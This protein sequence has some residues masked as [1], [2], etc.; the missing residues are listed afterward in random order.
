M[1]RK[2]LFIAIPL[3]VLLIVGLFV[4]SRHTL[5]SSEVSSILHDSAGTPPESNGVW[6][7]P[8]GLRTHLHPLASESKLAEAKQQPV[9]TWDEWL[10]AT[11]EVLLAEAILYGK[12]KTP[13]FTMYWRKDTQEEVA[14]RRQRL[15]ESLA[16]YIKRLQWWLK[17]PP[18]Y[19]G[20]LQSISE[21]GDY[22]G[23]HPQTAASLLDNFDAVFRD[24]HPKAAYLDEHYLTEV[25]LKTLLEKG[26]HFN[27]YNDYRFYLGVRKSLL[28]QKEKPE[29]W[30]SG[31]HDLP[32]TT[33][34]EEYS[35]GFIDRKVWEYN[36]VQKVRAENPGTSPTVYFDPH[37]PDKYFPIV[38]SMTYVNL[39]EDRGRMST[40]GTMLTEEQRENL[41]NK[42]IKPKGIE[43]IYLDDD[44]NVLS[45][46]PPLVDE[47]QRDLENMV[48]FDGIKV[49]PENYERLL[50]Q[51]APDK[52][53]ESYER[54]QVRETQDTELFSDTDAIRTAAREAASAA[55]ETAKSEFE[56]FQQGMRQLEEFAS[57]SDAEIEKTLEKQFRQK[58]L[59]QLPTEALEQLTPERLEN[60]LGTLF[61]HGFDEGFRRISRDSPALAEQLKQYF[62]QGQK[63]PAGKLPKG[64]VPPAPP[65]PPEAAP[66]GTDTD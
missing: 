14:L 23:S 46:P 18:E 26:A 40:F 45:E 52:W 25:W 43:I 44:N 28:R 33:N 48:S 51:P 39:G 34:F 20:S 19:P 65:A 22:Q 57:M 4:F 21:L 24:K 17:P 54:E 49:T 60:A 35:D 15:Q 66:P 42:G 5:F 9:G 29:E 62:G 1:R 64:P 10:D 12:I 32:I 61:Q 56:K 3:L 30:I 36:I 13:Y 38:G 37:D 58:F 47:R 11:V 41:L 2:T 16:R 8:R 53:L 50:G 55:Q 6:S 7:V 59:P 27:N 63:P 31:R